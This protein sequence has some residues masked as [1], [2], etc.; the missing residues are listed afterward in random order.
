MFDFE[1]Q[2][3]SK[4]IKTHVNGFCFDQICTPLTLNQHEKTQNYRVLR[5]IQLKY[6]I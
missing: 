6:I 1:E 4:V 2:K 3:L 5:N